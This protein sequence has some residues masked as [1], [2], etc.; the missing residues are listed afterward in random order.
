MRCGGSH[1]RIWE[2]GRL[3]EIQ[4]AREAR[5]SPLVQYRST[6][7]DCCANDWFSLTLRPSMHVGVFVFCSFDQIILTH[8]D[9][10]S[11]DSRPVASYQRR[12]TPQPL[13]SPWKSDS[14]S[15]SAVMIEQSGHGYVLS[16]S[17]TNISGTEP[18]NHRSRSDMGW[19]QER[20]WADLFK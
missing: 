17:V 8:F 5:M 19:P 1:M 7:R 10:P 12:M 11:I 3:E 14:G 18:C 15:Q 9:L 4:G 6:L 2:H 13:K 16:Q 20:D